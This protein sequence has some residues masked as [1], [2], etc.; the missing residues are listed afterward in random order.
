MTH[1][2]AAYDAVYTYIDSI[3]DTLPPDPAHRNAMIWRAVQAALDAEEQD[4][5]RRAHD[6]FHLGLRLTQKPNG[7]FHPSFWE[8][9]EEHL[10]QMDTYTGGNTSTRSTG[11]DQ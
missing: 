8:N 9:P 11:E 5:R 7:T 6:A 1:N 3:G 2:K 4:S 10:H